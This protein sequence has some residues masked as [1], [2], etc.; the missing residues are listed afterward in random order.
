MNNHQKLIAFTAMCIWEWIVES[1]RLNVVSDFLARHGSC[2]ARD[3]VIE[4]AQGIEDYCVKEAV[5]TEILDSEYGCW[6]WEVIP[7]L[8]IR[9]FGTHGLLLETDRLV[10]LFEAMYQEAKRDYEHP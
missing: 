5:D 8:M 10:A 7:Q 1:R 9:F 2:T 3:V 6:D 4:W